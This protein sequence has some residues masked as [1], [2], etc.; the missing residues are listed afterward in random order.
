MPKVRLKTHLVIE[1]WAYPQDFGFVMEV[2]AKILKSIQCIVRDCSLAGMMTII[3][4][5]IA[6]R[7]YG[8]IKI[9]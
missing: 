9:Q 7:D 3:K 2:V 8:Y 1:E 5:I 6:Q 4:P